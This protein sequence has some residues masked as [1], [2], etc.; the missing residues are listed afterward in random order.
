MSRFMAT[1]SPSMSAFHLTLSAV[2][3]ALASTSDIGLR[4]SNVME[5][6]CLR[7][8]QKRTLDEAATMSAKCQKP[9]IHDLLSI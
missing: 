9:T 3:S 2:M 1:R 6:R 4:K 5:R 7:S 8:T